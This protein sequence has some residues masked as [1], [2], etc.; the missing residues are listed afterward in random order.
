MRGRFRDRMRTTYYDPHDKDRSREQLVWYMLSRTQQMFRYTGL[1][2][3]I[4][5]RILEL[6]LQTNGH[7]AF[8]RHQGELYV[9]TGGLGGELDVYYMPTIYTIANPAQQ[10]SVNAKIGTDCIVVPNDALYL[11]LLPMFNRYAYHM[12]E[13]ELSMWVADINSRTIGLISAQDDR[14][15][16]SARQ[17]LADIESGKPGVIAESAFLDGV[18]SQPYG[19]ASARGSLTDLIEYEQYLKASWFNDLGLDSNYNMKRESLSM[20]ESQMNSD[21]LLPLV[22]DMLE[23]RQTGLDKVNSLFG[24]DIHVSLSSAW[25]DNQQQIDDMQMTE[26]GEVPPD[27]DQAP[28][29][30]DND[31]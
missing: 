14:T 10:L 15:I 9:Y 21:A 7:C 19:G 4:P 26:E 11:G 2:D 23:S 24:T 30:G 28:E 12:A 18:R 17:Y 3:T 5:A 29:E 31:V 25:E 8:Y 16:A 27:H 1:P 20:A 22:D 6:Y 13:N